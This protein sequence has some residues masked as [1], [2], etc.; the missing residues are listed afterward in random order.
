M[1][2][3]YQIFGSFQSRSRSFLDQKGWQTIPF[4]IYPASPIHALLNHAA[5]VPALL[6]SFD[7][8]LRY[9]TDNNLLAAHEIWLSFVKVLE[10][11][12]EWEQAY[13]LDIQHPP[14]WPTASRTT[15]HCFPEGRCQESLWFP[16]LFV[17]NGFTHLW[18]LQIVCVMHCQLLRA[19]FPELSPEGL[20]V[21][22]TPWAQLIGENIYSIARRICNSIEFLL[23]DEGGLHAEATTLFPLRVV[24]MVFNLNALRNKEQMDWCQGIVNH[25]LFKGV[26]LSSLL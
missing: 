5:H 16:N 2:T 14:Y 24:Y 18:A 9:P 1:V 10:L 23:Q 17:A 25:L 15:L 21:A 11:L 19:Q 4:K 13:R 8:L 7:N 26:K 22:S 20:S 3:I 12:S 6:E